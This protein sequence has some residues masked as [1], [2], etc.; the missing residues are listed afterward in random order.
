MADWDQIESSGNV[1][2]RRGMSPAILTGGGGLI[3]ILLALGLNYL[4]LN[5]SPSDVQQGINI[6]EELQGGQ[7]SKA[8]QPAEFRGEDSYEL[9]AKK[10]LGSTNEVWTD[11]FSQTGKSYAPPTL[12]LFRTATD[13][14][15]GVAPSSVG[16]FY[17]PEDQRIYMDETFFDELRTRFGANTGEA[18]Q[19]YVIA[20]EVGHHVQGQLGQLAGNGSREARIQTELQAD[21]YAGVW[22]FTQS[23]DGVLGPDDIAQV[24]NAASAVGDDNIQQ[25]TEG[26][27]TPESW[28]HGSSEQRVA[29]FIRG[30]ESGQPEK[31]VNF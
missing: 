1:E 2:D 8:E 30:H 14:A 24:M 5:I 18:A 20:H 28:T 3:A 10:V 29:A 22:T 7:A 16:P 31:C 21:C 15:C 6:V 19:A 13:S 12:V 11:I 17:C 23:A 27:I 25:R 9:F 4:G 26:Q